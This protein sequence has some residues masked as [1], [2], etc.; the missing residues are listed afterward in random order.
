MTPSWDVSGTGRRDGRERGVAPTCVCACACLLTLYPPSI[1]RL[2]ASRYD[3]R[4]RDEARLRKVDWIA[5]DVDTRRLASTIYFGIGLHAYVRRGR[6][7]LCSRIV[8]DFVVVNL[9]GGG[10]HGSRLLSWSVGN[11]G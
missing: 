8:V 7:P 1:S 10:G 3:P 5:W 4:S 9:S 6:G 2:G 11:A